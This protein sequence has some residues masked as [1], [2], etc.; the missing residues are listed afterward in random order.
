MLG[1][2]ASQ[3]AAALSPAQE[4]GRSASSVTLLTIVGESAKMEGKF[5]IA[6]SIHI[7]CEVGGE[8]NVGRVGVQ[9]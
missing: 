1:R 4:D 8:R 9:K 2:T 7:E 5:D 3:K 6:D